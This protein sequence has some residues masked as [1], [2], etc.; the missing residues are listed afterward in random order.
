MSKA[1]EELAEKLAMQIVHNE[2]GFYEPIYK[3]VLSDLNRLVEAAEK[4]SYEQ[5]LND[6]FKAVASLAV[7]DERCFGVGD[8]V[9]N[10]DVIHEKKGE[11]ESK[12]LTTPE[13]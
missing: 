13:R 11:L 6:F 9:T 12:F 2:T 1:N 8:L 7:P 5:A 4:R 10:M 3:E